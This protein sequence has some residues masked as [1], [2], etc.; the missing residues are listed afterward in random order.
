MGT[1][2][3]VKPVLLFCAAFS[4]DEAAISWAKEKM[5]TQ[6]GPVA[7][8]SAPIL[9]DEYT[10]YY[11]PSMGPHLVKKLWAFRNL[12][13]PGQLPAIKCQTNDWEDEYAHNH[14]YV[15]NGVQ[16]P[17]NLDPGYVT[18]AK[19]ILASTKDHAHRIY[20]GDGIFAETTLIYTKKTWTALPWTYPDYQSPGYHEFLYRCRELLKGD[21]EKFFCDK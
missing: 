8:E 2:N 13:D 21:M 14:G 9:F 12:I 11:T 1:I 6:F 18:L 4:A 19:L 15:L 10:D 16:R 7:L 5:E 3:P 20:L 17:L